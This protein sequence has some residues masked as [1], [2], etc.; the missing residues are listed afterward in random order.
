[1]P[2]V[3]PSASDASRKIE[4]AILHALAEHGQAHAASV[5]GV[6]ESSVSRMKDGQIEALSKLLAAIG[7]KVVPAQYKCLD[8]IK[9]QAMV[10]L[11]E[12][13]MQRITNPVELLFG[14]EA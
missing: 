8:P 10:T 6:S 9:A 7:L 1:M 14:D 2:E 4:R 13:A 11:Y 5:M 3:S 12:A